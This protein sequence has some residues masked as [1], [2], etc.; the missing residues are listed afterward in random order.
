MKFILV[1][2]KLVLILYRKNMLADG[3]RDGGMNRVMCGRI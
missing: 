3:W 1:V 2:Q